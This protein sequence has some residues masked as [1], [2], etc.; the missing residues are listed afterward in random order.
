[1]QNMITRVVV[2]RSEDSVF[3]QVIWGGGRVSSGVEHLET[4]GVHFRAPADS[5]GVVVNAGGVRE[6]ATLIVAGGI[7]P[8]DDIE[9]G[10]G[11]L[12]YLA[13]WRVFLNAEGQVCLGQ[14]EPE[15][16]A[17]RA[18]RVDE[19]IEALRADIAAIKGLLAGPSAPPVGPPPPGVWVPVPMDGGAALQIAAGAALAQIP[20]EAQ[21]VASEIVRL[22]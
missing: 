18:S 22:D 3:Y 4:Q 5:G 20:H 13:D 16:F 8:N 10:E 6:S 2:D 19:E 12:H 1:M 17:A 7:V 21:T 9:P 11:G 14:I 15:D